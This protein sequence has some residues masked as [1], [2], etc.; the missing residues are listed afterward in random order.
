MDVISFHLQGKM[1]HFRKFYANSSSLSYFIPPRTTLTGIIAGLLGWK[2]DQY[3]EKFS[4]D[5]CN[6]AVAICA[7]VKK[8]MQK[9]NLLMIKK[10]NDL[11]GSAAHHSQTAT[12]MIIPQNIR[13][14]LIDYKIWIHHQDSELMNMLVEISKNDAQSYKSQGIS[15]GL[16]TAYNLGW[17]TG[18]EILKGKDKTTAE[19]QFISSA[20][21]VEKLKSISTKQMTVGKYQLL[22]EKVPLEFDNNRNLTS[23]GLGDVVLNMQNDPVPANVNSFI[24]LENGDCIMWME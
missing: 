12:E 20:M 6:V 24:Q 4:L 10:D 14:G 7:P 13:T 19:T 2:R 16:G 9:M 15:L 8:C 1:A 23:R 22:K 18:G 5:L 3:Y 21:P 17:I 11:N